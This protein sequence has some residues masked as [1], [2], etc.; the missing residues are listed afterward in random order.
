MTQT[1]ERQA[2]GR[3]PLSKLLIC[4]RQII[5]SEVGSCEEGKIVSVDDPRAVLFPECFSPLIDRLG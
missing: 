3:T 4:T 2:D 1:K 5:R